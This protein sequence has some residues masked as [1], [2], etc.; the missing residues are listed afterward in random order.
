MKKINKDRKENN[1]TNKIKNI[2]RNNI[3]VIVALI[4]GGIITGGVVYAATAGYLYDS[5]E[6]QFDNTYSGLEASNVQ[7]ALDEAYCNMKNV[8]TPTEVSVTANVPTNSS[9]LTYLNV[10][11]SAPAG[12][13]VSITAHLFS[14]GSSVTSGVQLSTSTTSAY[15]GVLCS[16]DTS[17]SNEDCTITEYVSSPKTYYLWGYYNSS[18]GTAAIKGFILSN[19]E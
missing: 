10:S 16:S 4:V 13:F 3:K 1:K 17:A 7:D 6:V 18:G 8:P 19:T 12:S 11:Y 15:S 14:G 9:S 2:F 5:D